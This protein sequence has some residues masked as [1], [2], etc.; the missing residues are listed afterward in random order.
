MGLDGVARLVLLG[1]LSERS[2]ADIACEIDSLRNENARLKEDVSRLEGELATQTPEFLRLRKEHAILSEAVKSLMREGGFLQPVARTAPAGIELLPP[3]ILL[4]IFKATETPLYE[5]DPSIVRAWNP[6][7]DEIRFRKGLV[8]VCKAWSWSATALLYEDVVLRRMG[9]IPALARTL[10]SP[11]TRDF[12]GLIHHLRMDSCVVWAQCTDVVR[13]DLLT[14]LRQ[15]VALRSLSF[16][17][18]RNFPDVNHPD[19]VENGWQGFNPTWLVRDHMDNY[20]QTLRNHLS[21][22]LRV[23]D[24]ALKLTETQV[25]ELHKLLSSAHSLCS[26]KI[27]PVTVAGTLQDVIPALQPVRFPALTELQLHVN[28][29]A[30]VT[31]ICSRWYMPT[32]KSMTALSCSGLPEELLKRH[33]RSLT[34]LNICPPRRLTT[35]DYS[36][37]P[38]VVN[39]LENLPELCPVLDHFVFPAHK[40][41]STSAYILSQIRSPTLRYLDIWCHTCYATRARVE[42]ECNTAVASG[43]L[44]SL[45]RIRRLKRVI[46]P[47]IP[48]ICHPSL[49]SG[50]ETRLYR[51]PRAH[52]L[53]TSWAVLPDS[54]HHSGIECFVRLPGEDDDDAT[55]SDPDDSEDDEDSDDKEGDED[56][57]EDEVDEEEEEPSSP[58]SDETPWDPFN[59]ETESEGSGENDDDDSDG[60]VSDPY[61]DAEISEWE[62][63]T[64]ALR[65]E[66]LNAHYDRTTV[67]DI[68]HSTQASDPSDSE[69]GEEEEMSVQDEDN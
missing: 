39:S 68:F 22:W 25:V 24:I 40:P 23:L 47:D 35:Y 37:E 67:L 36:W 41:I 4:R 21:S 1:E 34:Y 65:E 5:H 62:L 2:I 49:V 8:L 16:H 7:L 55:F 27:G 44:P 46:H 51:F 14:I 53:Q 30:T 33:G 9:Q 11:G 12:G 6:W 54:G 26:L 20:G 45:V 3:E 28:H 57:D 52:F 50:D 43:R 66:Q 42:G 18:H 56:E 31:L 58:S 60:D 29:S 19:D 69:D 59:D 17:P 63:N 15:C 48:L 13:E 10:S 32:L 61:S 64:A 38:C